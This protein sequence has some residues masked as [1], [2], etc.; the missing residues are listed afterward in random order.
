MTLYKELNSVRWFLK[1]FH[2][3]IVMGSE[4]VLKT[5]LRGHRPQTSSLDSPLI[6]VYCVTN[7]L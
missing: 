1:E 6:K 7:S 2:A 4:Y 3:L 5:E